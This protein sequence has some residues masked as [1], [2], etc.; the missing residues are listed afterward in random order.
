MTD[1]TKTVKS[2]KQQ[3]T[4]PTIM[5]ECYAG[6]VWTDPRLGKL[7]INWG[8]VT[9]HMD[10]DEFEQFQQMIS[11]VGEPQG[12]APALERRYNSPT[13]DRAGRLVS[14]PSNN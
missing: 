1:T 6:A 8:G 2:P 14:F 10:P 13:G 7:S 12:L 4:E 5:S 9:L 3:V 11:R